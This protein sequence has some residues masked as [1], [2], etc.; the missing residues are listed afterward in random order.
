[1]KVSVCPLYT[2]L[3]EEQPSD[4]VNVVIDTLRMTS[5]AVTALENG[6]AR[7]RVTESPDEARRLA[8]ETGALLGGERQAVRIE[9]FD[10]SNSPLE[11]TKERVAGRSLVMTTT[12]G[13]RAVLTAA[14]LGRVRLG[15]LLNARALAR[16]LFGES[17]VRL[18]LAG[19][20]GR[21]SLEDAVTAGAIIERLDGIIE[22]FGAAMCELDDM[23][24]ASLMLWQAARDDLHARLGGVAHYR[25]LKSLGYEGDLRFCLT[26][27]A[28]DAVPE[29]GEDGWFRAKQE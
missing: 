19:T 8:A 17:E 5:V 14:R 21:F 28:L 12:N 10:L 23:A 18:V 13:T 3:K 25:R 9:G 6:C 1:M 4:A 16:S 20:N 7:L 26:L 15:C 27:D 11:Y 2:L 22:W 29:L 24:L